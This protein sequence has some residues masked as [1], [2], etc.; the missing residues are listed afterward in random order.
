M[1]KTYIIH[2]MDELRELLFEKSR[3]GKVLTALSMPQ[4][5]DP[6]T[7]PERAL[8]Y[9]HALW[10]YG[11]F[12]QALNVYSQIPPDPSYE[13][14]RLWGLA[15]AH[16]RLGNLNQAKTLLDAALSKNPSSWLLPRLYN[17]LVNLYIYKGASEQALRA[18]E[19]G[20]EAAQGGHDLTEQ[21]I[22]EGNRGVVKLNEG[23]FEEAVFLLERAT[24]QLL[25][26]GCIL[27]ASTFLINLCAAFEALGAR[28]EANKCLSRAEGLIQDSGS[29]GRWIALRK[30]QGELWEREGALTKAEEAFKEC[31]E[32]LQELPNLKEEVGVSCDLAHLY[33]EKGDLGLA[34]NLI[35]KSLTRIR[36]KELHSAEDICLGYE[37]KFLLR[38]GAIEKGLAVLNQA[39]EL[40][41]SMGKWD[42]FSFIALYLSWGHEELRQREE[43]LQWLQKSFQTAERCH[44]LSALLVEGDVLTSLLLKIGDELPLTD[45]LSKL[46]VQL[47]HPALLKRLLRHSPEGKVQFLKSL[48]I[49]DAR[50]FHPQLA[51]LRDDPAKEVRRTS[52]LLLNGWHQHAGYRLYAF[53]TFRVFLEGKILTDKDWIRPGVK[54][55]FLNLVTHPE[56]WLATES[57]LESLGDKPDPK[58][59]RRVLKWLFATLRTVLEPWHLSDMDYIFL[60][61]Q[62]GAYGFF[63]GERFWM[64]YRE[65]EEGIKYAEQ[66]QLQRNF[67]DARKAYREALDSYLGDYLEEFPY[68]DWL[69]P[70]RDHLRELYFRGVMR[71]ATLERDSGNLAEA[72]RVLEE[73]LFKDLSRSGCAALLIQILIQMKLTHEA[74]EWGQRHITYMKKELK[75]KPAPEVVEALNRL[76]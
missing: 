43:A 5:P 62:R 32:L 14:E 13:A 1:V 23:G 4:P 65:F 63:P 36:E 8:L 12:Q 69:N 60:K 39:R 44:M 28:S 70:K 76:K 58:R 25:V 21:L 67:K 18:I 16:L 48:K 29:K 27:S 57:L 74:K 52:R 2:D 9:G 35:R 7:E 22:L 71:Y 54:R 37:G 17:T 64:D 46:V 41:E 51:R 61:S 26:R 56:E 40:S 59:M 72:R 73:A 20:L 66:A 68:E 75:E 34:L 19:K 10:F 45:F 49:H 31:L 11:D 47:R 24:K 6:A 55:L 3:V 42:I 30:A 33:C 53:G 15:N 38:S 50:H